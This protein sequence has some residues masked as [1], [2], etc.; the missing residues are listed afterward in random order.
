MAKQTYSQ[1]YA[2]QREVQSIPNHNEGFYVKILANL[3]E[4]C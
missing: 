1:S 3:P 2:E 4:E